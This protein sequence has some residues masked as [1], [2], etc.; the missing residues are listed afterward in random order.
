MSLSYQCKSYVKFSNNK[1]NSLQ[2]GLYD[3]F[4]NY[5]IV[6]KVVQRLPQHNPKFRNTT[7]FESP[8]KESNDSNKSYRYAH[9]ISMYKSS[10]V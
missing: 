8:V 9:G 4:Q 7:N 6:H 3:I 10:F 1:I 5:R 2:V